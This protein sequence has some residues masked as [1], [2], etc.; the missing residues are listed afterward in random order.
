MIYT[1]LMTCVG[2]ELA[3]QLIRELKFNSRH[4]IKVIGVDANID[5]VGKY[6]CDEF[7]VVPFGSDPDYSS[8]IQKLVHIHN[9]DLVIPTS[10]EEAVA[11]SFSKNLIVKQGCMLA[12]V[13]SETLSLLTDKA[14]T[15]HFLKEQGVHVPETRIV[16]DYNSLKVTVESMY[17]EHGEVVVK[18]ARARGGRGVHIISSS[19]G[20]VEYFDDRR[21]VHTDLSTFINLLMKD[22]KKELPLIVMEK[23]VE[24]VI[25]IDLLAWKGK[26]IRVLARS[27]VNSA[28]PND[29]H[30]FIDDERL[31]SLGKK[32]IDIFHLSWLYDCDVMFDL[33]G[34][35]CVLEL[36]PRQSGS[37]AVTIAAGIPILDDLI[38]L[39]KGESIKNIE[40]LPINKRVVPYKSLVLINK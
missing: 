9:V 13:D 5:A 31:V 33:K 3:P 12:C 19:S 39:A 25:D 16:N 38:S 18:P 37:L 10:D 40:Q 7:S 32:L 35:P 2:G 30:I 29:G 1:V 15:Y 8:T 21:E 11:L 23:L 34:N 6:F 36:N 22:L 26:P 17:E 27:R 28:V 4:N 24:P 14:K 20:G